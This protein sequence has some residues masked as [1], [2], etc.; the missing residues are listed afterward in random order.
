MRDHR[1]NP[2]EDKD[3]VNSGQI[4]ILRQYS[5][6]SISCQS[7]FLIVQRSQLGPGK[8]NAVAVDNQKLFA[9]ARILYAANDE[10]AMLLMFEVRRFCDRR[11]VGLEV[12]FQYRRLAVI[13]NPNGSLRDRGG[14]LG[15]RSNFEVL[16]QG[17]SPTPG[18][19]GGVC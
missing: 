6:Q 9:H 16:R 10:W 2:V 15:D 3:D 8:N 18:K 17:E 7:S 5:S 12:F 19:P 14:R 1:S 4:L 13:V 11:A